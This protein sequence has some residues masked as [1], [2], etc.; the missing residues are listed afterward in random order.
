MFEVVKDFG[1]G[2]WVILKKII[3][4]LVKFVVVVGWLLSFILFLDDVIISLFV[5]G[6]IYEI[7]LLKIYLMVKVG[8]LF[9]VNV[10]VIVMFVVFLVFVVVL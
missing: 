6:L 10:L 5:I 2:E 9:E 1:V 7:L 8:I 3:L 4:L